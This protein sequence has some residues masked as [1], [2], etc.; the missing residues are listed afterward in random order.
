LSTIIEKVIRNK[1]G[2]RVISGDMAKGIEDNKEEEIIDD[3][4]DEV[5]VDL[6]KLCKSF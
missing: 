5:R 3:K 4:K 1:V 2:E 6:S